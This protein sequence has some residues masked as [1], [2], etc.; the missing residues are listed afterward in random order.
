MRS[1]LILMASAAALG[2]AL[3]PLRRFRRRQHAA[4]GPDQPQGS[5][6]DVRDA[7]AQAMRD[8]PVREW[9][10]VDEE[11]DESFPASDPPG[12]Y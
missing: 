11:L 4:Y 10:Q 7:G 12:H 8:E 6:L 3:W 9:T 5:H 2:F 1:S